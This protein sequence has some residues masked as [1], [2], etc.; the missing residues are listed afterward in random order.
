[1]YTG[2]PAGCVFNPNLSYIVDLIYAESDPVFRPL[3]TA[4]SSV[5]GLAVQSS[6]TVFTIFGTDFADAWYTYTFQV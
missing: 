6:T 2:A 4:P 1:M 3:T 5:A